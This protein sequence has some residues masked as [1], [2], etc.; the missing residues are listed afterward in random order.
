M[1]KG[2]SGGPVIKEVEILELVAGV[3]SS[4]EHQLFES[5]NCSRKRGDQWHTRTNGSN[6]DWIKEST[7]SKCKLL[8]AY[9]YRYNRCFD[10]PFINNI[11]YE[12]LKR[13]LATAIAISII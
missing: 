2:D 13:E 5:E 11:P 3:N 1:C 7:N 6:L 12:G 9:G 4:S 8:T 10:I